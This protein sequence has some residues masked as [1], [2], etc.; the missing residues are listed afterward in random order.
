[1]TLRD[2]GRHLHGLLELAAAE[3]PDA[4]VVTFVGDR[5]YTGNELLDSVLRVAGGLRAAGVQVGDRVA[6]MV[7]NRVEFL[8]TY[9]AISSL[10][11]VSVPLNTA[12][13][14][15]VLEYMLGSVAPCRL[16]YEEP[17]AAQVLPAAEQS[18]AV[19]DLWCIGEPAPDTGAAPFGSLLESEPL[20]GSYPAQPWELMSILFTSGTTGPSK[21][22][23]WSHATAFQVAEV[24][25]WVMGYTKDDIIYTCLPLFHINALFTAFIAALQQRAPV[26]VADRFSASAFWA[27]IR[28]H[29]VTVTNMLG[30][31]GSIL[32]RQDPVAEEK[33]HNLR[34][35]MVVPFP[36]GNDKAFEE[37]FET[38]IT[39]LY[40]STDTGIPLGVPFGQSRPGSCGIVTPGWEVMLANADDEP[41]PPGEPGELLTRPTRPFVGQLGYWNMPEKTWE[42]HRNCWFHTGDVLRQDDDGWYHYVDRAKDALRVSGENVSSFEVEQ[43]LIRH[44]LVLEA[45][46]YA[47]PSE[48][49]E[50]SVMAAIVVSDPDRFEMDD[51]VQ[52]AV[53]RLPYFAVPR[54]VDIVTELPKT[55]T[56]KVRKAALRERGITESAF[57]GGPRRRNTR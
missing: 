25:T 13:Q 47:V 17:F 4:P 24:S 49:G 52:F 30:A 9:L 34:L 46:V 32:W 20:A 39:E 27:Q 6:M 23:M 7:G 45:A 48:L 35:A 28:D 3:N 56:Q 21:G 22:V 43:V 42:A 16:I 50:D 2:S 53:P 54:Y 18:R 11:A 41:V 19:T 14:G 1:M 51:L 31:I 26:V 36:V 55:S 40:G 10:G 29:G 44:P 38:R 8:T 5:T 15:D 57:D 37:R 12:L 33:V